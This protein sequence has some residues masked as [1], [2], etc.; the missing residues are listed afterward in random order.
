MAD[1]IGIGVIGMGWMGEAHSRAYRQISDRFADHDLE[2]RLVMCSDALEE[3]AS[4]SQKRFGFEHST[5]HWREVVEH[6]SIDVIN[7]A[8]PNGLHLEMVEAAAQ[9]GKHIFCEKPVG[10][11]PAETAA[12]EKAAREAGVITFVGYNYR[13]A[14]MVQYVRE[15]IEHNKLGDLLYYR[16]RFFSCYASNPYG[17]LSWRFLAENG[18]GV[19]GDL[20][21]HVIDMAHML[22]GPVQETIG[23]RETFIRER[24]VVT[25]GEG[26]HFSVGSADSPMDD[27]TN[28]D[29]VSALVS[30]KNGIRGS[31]EG[32]R[33]FD[34][35]KCEMAF[36]LI[37]TD[38][39]VRWNFERMNEL[40]VQYR[41][42]NDADAGYSTVFGS[43]AHPYHGRINPGPGIGLG[44][45]DLKTIEA[46]EFLQAIRTGQQSPPGFADALTVADVQ[47]AIVRSWETKS[48]QEVTSTRQ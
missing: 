41:N 32:C 1:T 9:A 33:V 47:T 48:W 27:V 38:G 10:K 5:T 36:E 17:V 34:G 13:W 23:Q 45:E 37:G 31:L 29:Y 3:R 44:Y 42:A 24:P 40:D 20:M 43:P 30:F 4:A 39:A 26:T 8:A 7:I 28:E 14:P 25:P 22:A 18:L 21:S 11:D 12:C 16:G 6:P 15:L 19:L 2:P 35:P 46:F